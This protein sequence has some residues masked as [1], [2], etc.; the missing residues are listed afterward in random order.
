MFSER[1]K[2]ERKRLGLTQQQISNKLGISRSNVANWENGSNEA[3]NDMLLKCSQLFDC[4]IDYL[5]GKSKFRNNNE[6]LQKNLIRIEN[7]NKILTSIDKNS[8]EELALNNFYSFTTEQIENN[9]KLPKD[10]ADILLDKLK[11][12]NLLSDNKE[13]STEELKVILQFIENNKNM[14]KNLINQK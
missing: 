10:N 11:E 4:S 12:M 8:Q 7:T 13:L 3:S 2:N 5:L 14:L 9:A 6:F 1:F